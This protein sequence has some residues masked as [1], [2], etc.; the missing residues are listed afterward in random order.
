MDATLT[1]CTA[2]GRRAH[3]DELFFT[4]HGQVCGHCEAEGDGAIV[5][6]HT[7]TLWFGPIP[8]EVEVSKR[9]WQVMVLVALMPVLAFLAISVNLWLLR[10][11]MGFLV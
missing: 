3:P 1:R 11:L 7:L 2:C 9:T 4:G 10:W 8:V 6:R 5:E